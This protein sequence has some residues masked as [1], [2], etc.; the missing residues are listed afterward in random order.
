MPA[1]PFRPVVSRGSAP[2]F[3]AP[4]SFRSRG[5]LGLRAAGSSARPAWRPARPLAPRLGLRSEPTR[6]GPGRPGRARPQPPSVRRPVPAPTRRRV[7]QLRGPGHHFASGS[8]RQRYPSATS[9]LRYSGNFGSVPVPQRKR[10]RGATST[11]CG[12]PSFEKS[13]RRPTLPG[14]CPPS[15]IGA[16]GLHF[17]VRN[18]NG[19]F[20]AAIA[21]GNLSKGRSTFKNSIASTSNKDPKPSAD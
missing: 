13:R 6:A 7:G 14:G 8:R 20:P 5:W 21:T 18:G 3:L 10:S 19:C 4:A 17:R 1:A 11:A 12:A 2:P 15:T 16:G 9:V